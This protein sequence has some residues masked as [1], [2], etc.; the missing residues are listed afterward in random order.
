MYKNKSYFRLFIKLLLVWFMLSLFVRGAYFHASIFIL[1]VGTNINHYFIIKNSYLIYFLLSLC[2]ILKS[3]YSISYEIKKHG[4]LIE[5][6][7][8]TINAT[9]LRHEIID[10][11]SDMDFDDTNEISININKFKY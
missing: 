5:K 6:G 9:N 10:F 3:M 4:Q 11:I 1:T 2:Q 7:C 8:D